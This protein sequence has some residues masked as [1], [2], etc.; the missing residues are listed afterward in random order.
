V[1][2]EP[3]DVDVVSVSDFVPTTSGLGLEQ[4]HGNDSVIYWEATLCQFAALMIFFHWGSVLDC[5]DQDYPTH[6][7]LVSRCVAS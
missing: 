5:Y 7:S 6:L 2:L 4:E 3:L 1:S